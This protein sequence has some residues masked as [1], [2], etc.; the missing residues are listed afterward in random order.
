[1]IRKTDE[2]PEPRPRKSTGIARAADRPFAGVDR[3]SKPSAHDGPLVTLFAVPKRFEG[4]AAVIQANAIRSWG[5]LGPHVE[6]ILF[7]ESDDPQLAALAEEIGA[8]VV[9]LESQ[10]P[11]GDAPPSLDEVF[12]RVHLMARGEVLLYTNSDLIFGAALLDAATQ[13]A[14]SELGSWLAIGQRTDVDSEAT[15]PPVSPVYQAVATSVGDRNGQLISAACKDYFLFTR[16]QYQQIPP[17]RVGRGNWDNWI[18]WQA[19]RAGIPVVDIT[20]DVIVFHQRHHHNHVSG[21]RLSAYVTGRDARSNQRLAGGRHLVAGS[22]STWELRDGEILP[23]RGQ[24][25]AFAR[26]IPR[27]LRLLRDLLFLGYMMVHVSLQ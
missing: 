20:R 3:F 15:L 7:A 10:V 9:P 27:F 14:N 2:Q 5:Q 26:E 23:K 6:V 18:V 1:M 19:H 11:A 13:L 24:G 21:G 17:F 25:G 12:A 16:D 22:R 8:Q 4:A